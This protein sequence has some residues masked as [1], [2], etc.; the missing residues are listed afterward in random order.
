LRH[1]F[2]CR[3]TYHVI[4]QASHWSAGGRP[5]ENGLLPLRN[6]CWRHL[7]MRRPS[8]RHVHTPTRRKFFHRTVA[9][10]CWGTAWPLLRNALSKSVTICWQFPWQESKTDLK[11]LRR[12]KKVKLFLYQTVEAHR[13]VRCRGSHIFQTIGSQ[14][15]VRLSALRTGRHI[16]GTHF[17]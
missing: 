3:V 2:Y 6:R 10:S 1:P 8:L 16:P 5:T 7:R 15:A 12:K 9:S 17:C 14:M 11:I 13:V 4:I